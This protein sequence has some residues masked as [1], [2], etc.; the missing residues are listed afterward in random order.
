MLFFGQST[1]ATLEDM[2]AVGKGETWES[3][4]AEKG[5]SVE[6]LQ[7]ANP[8]VKANKKLRKGTL[9]IVPAKIVPQAEA[10]EVV[11]VAETPAP[12]IRTNIPSLK[13]GVL[14]PFS[15]TKMVAFYRGLLMAAD[16]VRQ[17]GTNI[18]IHAWNCGNTTTN[19]E[20]ILPSLKG[21]DVVFGPTSST[22]TAIVAEHCQKQGT[23]LVIPFWSGQT[24]SQY[25]LVYNATAPNSVLYEAAAKKIKNCFAD[26]NFVIVQCE[27]SDS[28]S[29][30]LC[31]ALSKELKGQ[32]GVLKTLPIE[33]SETAYLAALDSLKGNVILMDNSSMRMLSIMTARIK[34]FCQKH[35]SFSLSLIGH[36][37]WLNE[38]D[39][40]LEDFFTANTYVVS[41]HYF[42]VLDKKTM[43]FQR[44]YEKNFRVYMTISNPRYAALG[45]DLGYYFLNGLS[46][47]GDNFEH[48]QSN[49]QQ[50]PYQ[51][52]FQFVRDASGLSFTNAFVQLVHYSPERKIELIR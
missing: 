5:I 24:L 10:T 8:D 52:R 31:D 6:E 27:S 39:R 32:K 34:D 23:R 9:L 7:G 48:T 41:P 11:E 14:L 42:N 21:M 37:E 50:E 17:S 45:F 19:I 25:P 36:P 44:T 20:S 47:M 33:G 15:D 26:K 12:T 49:L 4:A 3:I 2:H 43:H 18:D 35:P 46:R 40:Y 1:L 28:Q 38:T 51:N 30:A 13:V 16:S 29:K 22:Q